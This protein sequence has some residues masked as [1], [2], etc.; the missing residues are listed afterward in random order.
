MATCEMPG[1]ELPS[2]RTMSGGE[3]CRHH[4]PADRLPEVA[5]IRCEVCGTAVPRPG[6]TF[7]DP[8]ARWAGRD[9]VRPRAV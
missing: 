2:S 9:G 6:A 7:C 1:C 4:G 3:Y 5:I 8:H